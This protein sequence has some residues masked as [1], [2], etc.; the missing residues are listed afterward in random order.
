[1]IWEKGGIE[2]CTGGKIKGR[3]MDLWEG[4]EFERVDSK[5]REN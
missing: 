5:G 3:R 1:M 4:F 2:E